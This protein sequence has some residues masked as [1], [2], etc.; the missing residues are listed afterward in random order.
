MLLRALWRFR[1]SDVA[2]AS[3]RSELPSRLKDYVGAF[4]D[5]AFAKELCDRI[6]TPGRDNVDVMAL[7]SAAVVFYARCFISGRTTAL[8]ALVERSMTTAERRVHDRTIQERHKMV[9]HVQVA[10]DEITAIAR[11]AVPGGRVDAAVHEIRLRRFAHDP[12]QVRELRDLADALC[13]V[14]SPA[15]NSELLKMTGDAGEP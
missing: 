14:L 3:E 8:P 10:R 11:L 13:R 2:D 9:A 1:L 7:W 12:G 4:A 5:L 6:L 15:L